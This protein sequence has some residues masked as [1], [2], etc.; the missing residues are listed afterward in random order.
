MHCVH[1]Q[2]H[3]EAERSGLDAVRRCLD[4]QTTAVVL[5]DAQGRAVR[6]NRAANELAERVPELQL[7]PGAIRFLSDQGQDML[8]PLFERARRGPREPSRSRWEAT[9][10][11]LRFTVLALTS[12]AADGWA[13]TGSGLGL[14]IQELGVWPGEAELRGSRP[15]PSASAQL[16]RRLQEHF[17]LT[18]KEVQL[19]H[20]LAMGLTIGAYAERSQRSPQTLR[21]QVKSIFAKLG[22]H[23]QKSLIL[24]VWQE[25][26]ADWVECV[27]LLL[28]YDETSEPQKSSVPALKPARPRVS[29]EAR[30]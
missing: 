9:S 24:R 14:I 20:A 18:E 25:R 30:R 23:D 1:L 13:R 2:Q 17:G 7:G 3:L 6:V 5:S 16:R 22:V 19:A 12:P 4:A 15:L 8:E 10:G 28:G 26:Q 29:E 27:N 11:G 21:K